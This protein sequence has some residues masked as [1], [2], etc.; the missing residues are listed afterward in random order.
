M[1]SSQLKCLL[2]Q[3]KENVHISSEKIIS[4]AMLDNAAIDKINLSN[5]ILDHEVT[6]QLKKRKLIKNNWQL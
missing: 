2:S 3:Q 4:N 6:A 5:I 1:Y